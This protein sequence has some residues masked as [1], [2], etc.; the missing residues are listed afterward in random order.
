MEILCFFAGIVFVYSQSFYSLFIAF[1]A[2]F[3]RRGWQ[4]LVWFIIAA[5]WAYA[6]QLWSADENMPPVAVIQQAVIQGTITSIPTISDTRTQFEF[7]VN[8]LDGKVARADALI[9]CYNHCP[10]FK[11][12][13]SWQL[14]VKLKKPENLGNPGSFDYKSSL[15][16]RHISWSGYLKGSKQHLLM[17]ASANSSLSVLREQLAGS[18][19]NNLISRETLGIIQALTLGVTTNI[20]KSQW[21]LFRRTGTTHLMVISGSHIALVAGLAYWIMLRLWSLSSRLCLYRPAFQA[22]AIA[23]LIVAIGY[24]LL[25]GFAI[26]AQRSL[27]ACIILFARYFLN[28]RYTGWQAWRY[29]LL[30]IL[31]IEPHAVLMAGF[32]LSFLA[33]AI[34]FSVSQRIQGGHFKMMIVLQFAC[35]F[36][37]MPF[38]LYWFSYGA[39]NGLFANL[40]AIP[41]VGYVIVPLSLIVLFLS[42]FITFPFMYVPVDLCIKWLMM[43][44]NWIDRFEMVNFNVPL[45]SIVSVFALTLGMTVL[46][47]LPLKTLR[48]PA[49]LLIIT[50]SL[51]ASLKIRPNHAR[52][53]ILDVGQGLAIVV[54][55]ANHT[56]IYDTGMKF[57]QGSD[58]GQLA[59]IPY[60]ATIG[61]K[62]IDKII[63]SHPDLD[64]RGGLASLE[65]KYPIGELLV[66]NVDFYHRGLNCHNYP[67]WQWDGIGFR[68]LAIKQIFHDKNN[69][70]CVL[71]ISNQYGRVLLTGDIEK[72]AEN[73]LITRYKQNLSSDVLIVAHHGSKTS[74][75][76]AFIQQVAPRYAV[77]SAGFDN[78]YHFPHP[79]T[80][81]TL[82]Q[83]NSEIFN[84]ITCGMVTIILNDNAPGRPSCYQPISR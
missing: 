78:R 53:D 76:K 11:A 44:L 67:Q 4:T 64:H 71:Q 50:A 36:G 49:L 21:E 81:A 17:E 8:Q 56:L 27:I 52:I 26:P 46:V 61:V 66:D 51:P 5:S 35:L 1:L 82:I 69:S 72:L 43:Y 20:S 38:T 70:S 73:Y 80:M 57:Y 55:T 42:Q 2:L 77:I 47:F 14:Q 29:A 30:I 59:I 10:V 33:V 23:G 24:S 15:I 34:L 13:Q 48:V 54:K 45:T 84:T 83:H 41:L 37:L 16:A 79:K 68:F 3:F 6:H 31:I 65:H 75:T 9:A 40:I 12:G 32:Y 7:A 63:I 28:H 22:A 39:V 58:M 60:L 19:Q 18:L 74:S 25:A 62:K